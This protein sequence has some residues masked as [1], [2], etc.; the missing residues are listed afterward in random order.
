MQK[1]L[2]DS[3]FVCSNH[4]WQH[5]HEKHNNNNNNKITEEEEGNAISM[6]LV[7]KL[8]FWH[9]GLWR[10]L[11]F[12]FLVLNF[13]FFCFCWCCWLLFSFLFLLSSTY[14]FFLLCFFF[15][16][17]GLDLYNFFVADSYSRSK[18]FKLIWAFLR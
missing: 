11:Y 3:N 12:F 14:S 16:M 8:K 4:I 1:R 13:V 7:K 6:L 17:N 2:Y 5:S 15:Y 10:G 9:D 18:K